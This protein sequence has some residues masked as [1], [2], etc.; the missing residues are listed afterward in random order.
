MNAPVHT[1]LLD[2]DGVVQWPAEGWLDNWRRHAR[3]D[4]EGFTAAMW[5]AE[6]PALDGRADLRDEVA[7]FLRESDRDE[8][9]VDEICEAWSMIETFEPALEMVDG[10]R[11]AGVR[12]HLATNQQT[13]RRDI[14]LG[15][16]YADRFDRLFFSC[17]LGVAKPDPE[18]FREILRHLDHGPQGVV[19]ID[20]RLDNVEAARSVGIDAHTHNHHDSTDQGVGDLRALLTRLGVAGV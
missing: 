1:L 7:R 8:N 4:I 5:A 14:M 2:A 19:F 16:G 18:Y 13:Y 6:E 20:D 10:I 11:T 12:V 9:T 17:D 3:G 15:R